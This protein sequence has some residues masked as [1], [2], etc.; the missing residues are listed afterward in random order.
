MNI[1]NH[2]PD[3]IISITRK[4]VT[5]N[6]LNDEGDV[7]LKNSNRFPVEVEC[8]IFGMRNDNFMADLLVKYP[9]T[10]GK[11]DESSAVKEISTGINKLPDFKTIYYTTIIDLHVKK[12]T[13][14]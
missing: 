7:L 9:V 11:Y 1:L 12:I 2:K 13:E 8:R 14:R 4:S 10:L 3:K 5:A 6:K